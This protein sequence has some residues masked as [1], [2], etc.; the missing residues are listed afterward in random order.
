MEPRRANPRP[1]SAGSGPR[2]A[3]PGPPSADPAPRNARATPS[4]SLLDEI[5][6]AEDRDPLPFAAPIVS[7]CD[8]DE[9]AYLAELERCA[10]DSL[11]LARRGREHGDW[12]ELDPE[13]LPAAR[14]RDA[15]GP[16]GGRPPEAAFATLR[17]R[18]LTARPIVLPGAALELAAGAPAELA[19]AA[20]LSAELPER[21]SL[22][23]WIAERGASLAGRFA[24]RARRAPRADP[25][26]DI[27]LAHF[28][29]DERDRRGRPVQ[30]LWVKSSWLSTHDEDMSLRL[31]VSFGREVADDASRDLVRLRLAAELGAALLPLADGAPPPEVARLIERLAGE[32]ALF[33][34]PIG[35]W[36]APGGGALFHHD[37]FVEDEVHGGTW[38]QLG[39]C[40]LQLS[41]A[42]A[43]LA[44]SSADLAARIAEFAEALAEGEL[45]WVRAQLFEAPGAPYPGGWP[46]FR[47]LAGERERAIAELALPGCGRLGALV[48]RGP[49]FTAFLADAGHACVLRAGDAI[50]LPN[51]GLASTCM[52]SVFCAGD[53]TAYSL[54]LAIRPDREPP[55]AALEDEARR[56][57]RALR[58]RAKG[59]ARAA[60]PNPRR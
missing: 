47:A 9:E 2:S 25:E 10:T 44:L 49:E 29:S 13:R 46:A 24:P 1:R 56:R 5:L 15:R 40:Y 12:A 30:D 33:T 55:E 36:N 11:C 7:W 51:H 34:Q 43:W 59:S 4:P 32:R 14:T 38:R 27:A 23:R 37:A 52:H 26:R 16:T 58:A 48:D 50:L 53:D 54:S 57:E 18:W 21:G 60:G 22:A 6:S 19:R 45:P 3:D 42:T 8:R 20:R 39:V 41:G 17:E 35:Y 31:R 28:E